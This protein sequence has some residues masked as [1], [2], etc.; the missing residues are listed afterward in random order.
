MNQPEVWYGVM[1]NAFNYGILVMGTSEA[2]ATKKL[3]KQYKKWAKDWNSQRSFE[4]AMED[5]GGKIEQVDFDKAYFDNF[6]Y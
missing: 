3:K 5:C 2:D 1:P 6:A 4:T